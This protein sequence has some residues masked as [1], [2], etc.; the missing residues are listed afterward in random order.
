M[1]E[2]TPP[3]A[4]IESSVPRRSTAVVEQRANDSL[5]LVHVDTGRYYALEGTGDVI[6]HLCDG[7]NTLGH[8]IA[9]VSSQFG[10]DARTVRADALELLEELSREGLVDDAS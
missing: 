5:V 9:T 1:N 4:W 8:I 7:Q 2:R 3:H 10:K 6:W